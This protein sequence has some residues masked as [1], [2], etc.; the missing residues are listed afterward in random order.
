[1]STTMRSIKETELRDLVAA[2]L[3]ISIAFA[4][5]YV[6]YGFGSRTNLD[7]GL[8]VAIVICAVTAGVAFLL[9]ELAHKFTAQRFGYPAAFKADYNML[10]LA[11]FSAMVG[12]LFA[13]PGAVYH[14]QTTERESGLI[15]LAGPATNVALLAVFYPLYLFPGVV[16]V[17]GSL[18][19]WINAFLAGF[20]MIPYGPLDGKKV[21]NWS[22]PVYVASFAV[23]GSLAAGA[24][25][26]YLP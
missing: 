25:I 17:V 23:C 2:W 12:F 5:L 20:N 9:H 26:G 8:P 21:W 19:V 1:M 7:I 10:L 15:A 22:K 14:P 18:G 6:V 24:F 3:G 11:V 16:G 13:A 4:I